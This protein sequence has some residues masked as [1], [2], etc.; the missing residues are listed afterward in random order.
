MK[1]FLSLAMAAIAACP[2]VSFAL[3]G[4]TLYPSGVQFEK[5]NPNF[6]SA[7]SYAFIGYVSGVIDSLDNTAFCLPITVTYPQAGSIV[8]K[9]LRNNPEQRDRMASK[10]VVEALKKP[11]PCSE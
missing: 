7:I 9:Y 6:E 4:N 2:A 11:F 5:E 3:S 10:L 1:G 8:M